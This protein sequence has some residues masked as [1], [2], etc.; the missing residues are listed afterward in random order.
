[1]RLER[2]R[3]RAAYGTQLA[4]QREFAC[5]FVLLQFAAGNLP[6]CNENTQ[7]DRQI[8]SSALF[9]QIGG[10]QID[11]DAPLRKFEA[12]VE[13]C[14]A[15]AILALFYFRLGQADDSER[16]QSVCQM[17]FHSDQRCLHAGQRTGV[18]NGK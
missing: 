15:H 4:R 10:R 6:T 13:Q 5:E 7:R 1:M 8:E 18:E 14:G 16:G 11:G 2:H 12:R 3:Q 9:R 17:H